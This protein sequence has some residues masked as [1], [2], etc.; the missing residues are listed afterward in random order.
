MIQLKEFIKAYAKELKGDINAVQACGVEFNSQLVTKDQIFFAFRGEH[1]DGHDYLQDAKKKGA[2]LAVVDRLCDVDIAQIC[3][4]D[5]YDAIYQLAKL[6]RGGW[7]NKKVIALT[8]SVGKTS[9]K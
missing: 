9:C 6:Q 5:T 4:D 7:E 1:S 3:V 8:G 2:C